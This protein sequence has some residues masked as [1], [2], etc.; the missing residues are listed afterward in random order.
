MN[1]MIIILILFFAVLVVRQIL[2]HRARAKK[3]SERFDGVLYRVG[4]AVV[5]VRRTGPSPRATVLAMHGFMEDQRYFVD[6]YADPELELILV[7]SADYHTP[8]DKPQFEP[9]PWVQSIP[10]PAGTIEYDAAVLNQALDNLPTTD[11]IRLHGHSRGGAVVLEA[12]AQRPDLHRDLETVLEAP[13]LPKIGFHPNTERNFGVIGSWLLPFTLPLLARIPLAKYGDQFY[14]DLGSARKQTLLASLPDT[15]QH[16][17]TLIK[18][19]KSIRSWVHSRGYDIYRHINRGVI[20]VGEDDR[21]LDR[22]SMLESARH[23]EGHLAIIEV[24]GSTH[25]VIQDNTSC[26]PPL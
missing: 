5:A 21:V 11:N 16:Y 15:P 2:L 4:E 18:N 17:A 10:Y 9:A 8:V 14:G 22:S 23:A 6:A 13:V 26:L 7:T 24:P 19:T 12:A 20:L 25:F 3:N 1:N